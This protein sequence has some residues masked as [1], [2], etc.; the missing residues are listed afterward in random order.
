MIFVE[1]FSV[2]KEVVLVGAALTG[3]VVA[4]K[5]LGAW[6]RQ[7]HG[8]ADYELSRRLL[9]TVFKYRDAV[10]RVRDPHMFVD[11]QP[12]PPEDQSAS[13][14]VEQI[15]YYGVSNAYQARWEKVR[16]ER[17]SLYADLLESE[18]LWG[19][20]CKDFFQVLFDL[21][22]E[23]FTDIRQYLE[24][25]NPQTD[26]GMKNTLEDIRRDRRKVMYDYSNEKPDDFKQEVQVAINEIE[27]YLKPKLRHDAETP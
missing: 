22:H 19:L 4:V 15:R 21:E 3:A 18:A 10:D 7:L 27:A 11:E 1:F 9:V 26:Q 8:Q 25:I 17:S 24:L 14:N 23:L 2:L 5:G 12:R 6:Q 13:M 16:T 20:T